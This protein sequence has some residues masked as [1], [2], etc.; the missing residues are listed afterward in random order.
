MTGRNVAAEA[1]ILTKATEA[2]IIT[3]HAA[4]WVADYD[5]AESACLPRDDELWLVM[6]AQARA[7]LE[8]MARG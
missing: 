3:G 4:R 8:E 1:A 7:L 2:R 5:A 6:L